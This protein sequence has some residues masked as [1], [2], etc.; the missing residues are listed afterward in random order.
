GPGA[1]VWAMPAATGSPTWRTFSRARAKR[2]GSAMGDPSRERIT[3]SGR[4]GAMPAAAMSAPV[5]TATTP[6]EPSAADMS[7]PRM[8]ACGCGERTR[9]HE[10][11][12]EAAGGIDIGDEPSAAGQKAPILDAAQRDAD[13]LVVVHARFRQRAEVYSISSRTKSRRSNADLSVTMKRSAWPP[14][15]SWRAQVQCGMVKTSCWDHSKVASPMLERPSPAT[16]RHT[17]L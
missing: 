14:R 8:A 13:G 9:A 16:T 12:G 7:I 11:A 3:H 15:A 2:G 17:M 4:I 5:S 10:G 1:G 6:D